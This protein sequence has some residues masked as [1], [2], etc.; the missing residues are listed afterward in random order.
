MKK[1][2]AILA[3]LSIAVLSFT[4]CISDEEVVTS[5]EC[6]IV[7]FSVGDIKSAVTVKN[8]SGKD[9]VVYKT[10]GGSEIKFNIDQVGG[11]IY[12]VDSLPNWTDLTA[13]VPT[14]SAYGN[15]FGQRNINAKDSLYYYITSSKDSLDLSKPLDIYVIATDGVSKK[16]YTIEMYKREAN[17]DTLEWKLDNINTTFGKNNRFAVAGNKLYMFYENNGEL[18]VSSTTNGTEWT[19]KNTSGIN[20]ETVTAFEDKLYAL[21]EDSYI[22]S[23]ADGDN[24]NKA[25]S[26]TVERILAADKLRLYA[27]DGAKIIGSSDLQTWEVYGD[28]KMDMLPETCISIQS[29]TSRTNKNIELV[30][31]VG[32]SSNNTDNA[33]SWFKVSA[34]DKNIDQKWTYT[35]NIK[36]D[37]NYYVYLAG[38]AQSPIQYII[39][40]D[41]NKYKFPYLE[42][43]STTVYDNAIFAIGKNDGKY[44]YIYRSDDNGISW[45]PLTSKYPLPEGINDDTAKATI[46][47]VGNELWIVKGGNIW[48]G[49]IQ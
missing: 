6:A 2:Y 13:V 23:S 9:T 20:Y 47:T 10:I 11:K 46:M 45:H 27:Y 15:V 37:D 34:E 1:I 16:H 43:L 21:G 7:S 17:T 35:E 4:S 36:V 18:F 25:S 26:V 33:V 29:I 8:A 39:Q 48:K 5:S 19:V 40:L 12:T 42:D 49:K 28:E 32:L 24:W 41:N 31:M 22:Y 44:D 14:F 38:S 30:T 3:P